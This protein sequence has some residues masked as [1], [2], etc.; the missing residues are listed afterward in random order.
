MVG[1]ILFAFPGAG[2]LLPR[3]LLPFQL[4][5]VRFLEWLDERIGLAVMGDDDGL[6][7]L[8]GSGQILGQPVL[9][10]GHA[11]KAQGT[12]PQSIARSIARLFAGVQRE[13]QPSSFLV[14]RARGREPSLLTLAPQ[15]RNVL[16][17]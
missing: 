7:P 14:G 1:G 9:D 15:G 17:Y 11:G 2:E 10:L 12:P 8:L 3:K 13:V 6:V 4:L 16:V 5:Q